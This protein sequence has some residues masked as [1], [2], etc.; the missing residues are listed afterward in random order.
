VTIQIE[1]NEHDVYFCHSCDCSFTYAQPW[2]GYI[3]LPS[4]NEHGFVRDEDGDFLLI[5]DTKILV[6]KEG[7]ACHNDDYACLISESDWTH[8]TCEMWVCSCGNTFAFD[9]DYCSHHE[10]SSKEDALSSARACCNDVLEGEKKPDQPAVPEKPVKGGQY[11]VLTDRPQGAN[12]PKNTVIEIDEVA[13]KGG[14]H[15]YVVAAHAVGEDTRWNC[16]STE[17][18]KVTAV[19]EQTKDIELEEMLNEKF[20]PKTGEKKK[21]TVIEF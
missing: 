3:F 13:E 7:Y 20:K 16:Y 9:N 11:V 1:T 10:H 8:P 4:N 21:V 6:G 5:G 2:Q 19:P 14:A 18:Q 15:G 17:L 12:W